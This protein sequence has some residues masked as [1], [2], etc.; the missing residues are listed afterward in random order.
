MCDKELSEIFPVCITR[1]DEYKTRAIQAL[2]FTRWKQSRFK[3][4]VALMH[5]MEN[6]IGHD[7]PA[8]SENIGH[9]YNTMGDYTKA[10]EYFKRSI[11]SPENTNRGRCLLGLGLVLDRRGD[12]KQA[13]E[14]CSEAKKWYQDK[15]SNVG[16]SSLVA[17]CGNSIAKCLEKLGRFSEAEKDVKES[18]RIFEVTCG[19]DSPL[20]ATACRNLGEIYLKQDKLVEGR[21]ALK[22]AYHLEAIKDAVDI[23]TLM[24]IHNRI[25]DS[26][27]LHPSYDVC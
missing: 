12:T 8:L 1:S 9:T 3:E 16:D 26:Y 19:S 5:E 22:R 13:L 21:S 27:E 6:I 15:M 11:E 2:A 4:S 7:D 18:I 17:K 25:F 23:L 20:V 24:E 14:K 10:E